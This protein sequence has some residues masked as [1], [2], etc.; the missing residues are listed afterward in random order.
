M[1]RLETVQMFIRV[2]FIGFDMRGSMKRDVLASG[3]IAPD[4]KRDEL[5]HDSGGQKDGRFHSEEARDFHFERVEELPHS[6]SIGTDIERPGVLGKLLEN[7]SR[8]FR[9]VTAE[10]ARAVSH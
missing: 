1:S 3:A 4:A 5:G 6:I 7:F 8:S 2:F 10:K 9:A